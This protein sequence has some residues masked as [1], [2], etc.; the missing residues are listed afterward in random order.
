LSFLTK[1]SIDIFPEKTPEPLAVE[2]SFR[3]NFPIAEYKTYKND[4][5]RNNLRN[6]MLGIK[7]DKR[8]FLEFSALKSTNNYLASDNFKRIVM[9]YLVQ[10]DISFR[11]TADLYIE[12]IDNNTENKTFD[13]SVGI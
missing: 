5:D 9:S 11:E 12:K 7:V 3:M 2:S 1:K 8:G 4:M 6:F 13:F 10:K